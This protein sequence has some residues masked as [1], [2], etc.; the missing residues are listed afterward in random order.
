VAREYLAN[1]GFDP[2]FGARPLK[3]LIQREIA[4]PLAMRVLSGEVHEG[5][6]IRIDR[7]ED[8][9]TFTVKASKT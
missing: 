5:D 6:T 2:T 9:L 8:G 7:G 3:R 1:K 4:D